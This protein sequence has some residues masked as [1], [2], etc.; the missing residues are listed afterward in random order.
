MS[1]GMHSKPVL[2]WMTATAHPGFVGSLNC[3]HAELNARAK[4][5]IVGTN[6]TRIYSVTVNKKILGWGLQNR[7]IRSVIA[8]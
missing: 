2:F 4:G 6:M 1:E 8:S 3:L 5:A 7:N